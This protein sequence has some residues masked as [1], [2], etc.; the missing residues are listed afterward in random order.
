MLLLSEHYKVNDRLLEMIFE[1]FAMIYKL[2]PTAPTSLKV[3]ICLKNIQH[4][5]DYIG[6]EFPELYYDDSDHVIK[7]SINGKYQLIEI[8]ES[9]IKRSSDVIDM[10]IEHGPKFG[11]PIILVSNKTSAEHR[12]SMLGVL[13][14]LNKYQPT[15][16]HRFKGLGENDAEDIK[17]TVMD[18]NT[19]ILIKVTIQDIEN[20]MK[21]FQLLRGGSPLDAQARK[22]MMKEYKIPRE[23]IDT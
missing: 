20:D 21:I 11:E 2:N 9:M 15:I 16:V 4:L 1:E 17:T 5:M 14:I 12:L 3:N 8:S 18:P 13:K 19:R 22:Q 6:T 7:G 23:L 10:I